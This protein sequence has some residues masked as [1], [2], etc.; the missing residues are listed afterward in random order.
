MCVIFA[1]KIKKPSPKDLFLGEK[2]NPDG[3][4]IAWVRG[5]TVYWKK[6]LKASDIVKLLP[7]VNL[8]LVIH[9]RLA[10]VGGGSSS[11]C[12]PF[13]ITKDVPLSLEGKIKGSVLAHNGTWL[14]WR[15]ICFQILL[16]K[17]IRC[18]DGLWSDSRAMA[19]IAAHYG[20]GVLHFIGEKV[21]VLSPKGLK[22]FGTGW[23]LYNGM[24]VSNTHFLHS[25]KSWDFQSWDFQLGQKSCE[26]LDKK[27]VYPFGNKEVV[28]GED[29]KNFADGRS[30]L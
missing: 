8:P 17:N 25:P 4:G 18:P 9:F 15:K 23:E 13:P 30:S 2:V 7:K 22:I 10:S 26:V 14:E 6:N 29:K 5:K 27:E 12:H 21:A 11:L 16:R 19:W 20:I 24:L 3:A 28:Y 1:C